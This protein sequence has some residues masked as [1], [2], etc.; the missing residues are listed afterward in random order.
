MKQI[1]RLLWYM[2]PGLVALPITVFAATGA[3]LVPCGASAVPMTATECGLC[4]FGTLIQNLINYLL[5]LAVPISIALFAWA[6]I[7]YFTSVQNPKQIGT[8]KRLFKSVFIGFA[9]ALASWLII[10]T[11][12]T[13][14]LDPTF[15]G[16]RW[17]VLSCS[18]EDRPRASKILD[19]FNVV[20]AGIPNAIS[21]GVRPIGDSLGNTNNGPVYTQS[22]ALTA[23]AAACSAGSGTNCITVNSLD[24]TSLEGMRQATVNQIIAIQQGCGCNIVIT[25]GTEP[26]HS[27]GVSA[28]DT[29]AKVDLRP[30]AQLDAY[31]RTFPSAG[32]R[33]DGAALYRAGGVVY[34]REG[35]HWDILVQ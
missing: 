4:D 23:L 31:I 13:G 7:L 21:V 8:A 25:G 15:L 5:I 24:R 30:N 14:L 12:L 28:H 32:V 29:G 33:S 3:G 34:A 20:P 11:I 22:E 27:A 19:I 6:G 1:A 10:Q 2:W 16:G 9:L 17:N 26:G 35:D 18:S